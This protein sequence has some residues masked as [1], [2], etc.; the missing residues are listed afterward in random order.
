MTGIIYD[1]NTFLKHTSDLTQNVEETEMR[2][3]QELYKTKPADYIKKISELATK[4]NLI[5]NE[6]GIAIAR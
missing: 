3:V 4:L 6:A 5:N 2:F 1:L